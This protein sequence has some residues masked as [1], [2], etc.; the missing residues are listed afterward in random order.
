METSRGAT[1]ARPPYIAPE[2]APGK[3]S[4]AARISTPR[5]I[6]YRL[7]TG[8]LVFEAETPIQMIARHLQ[9]RTGP[10]PPRRL[11][12]PVPAAL[13]QLILACLAKKPEDRPASAVALARALTAID[14][15]GPWDEEL[16]LRWWE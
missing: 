3:G 7:L 9:R 6:V 12:L 8:K 5:L 13:D 10:A 16:A 14:G 11:E 4:T 1:P 2:K 15:G